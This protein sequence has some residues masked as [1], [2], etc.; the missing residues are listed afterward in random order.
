MNPDAAAAV[1]GGL[2]EVATE[3]QERAAVIDGLLDEAGKSSIAPSDAR[4]GAEL[5]AAVGQDIRMR[6]ELLRTADARAWP[7]AVIETILGAESGAPMCDA[8]RDAGGTALLALKALE[9]LSSG[10]E[11]VAQLTRSFTNSS[12]YV[13]ARA[14]E[15]LLGLGYKNASDFYDERRLP[16]AQRRQMMRAHNRQLGRALRTQGRA[17][18]GAADAVRAN[19]PLTSL[20][21]RFPRASK[22]LKTGGKALGAAGMVVNAVDL[23]GDVNRGDWGGAASNTAAMVGSGLMMSGYGAPVGAVLVAGSLIYEHREEIGKAAEWVGDKVGDVAGD[24]AGS[25]KKAAGKVGDF[26]GL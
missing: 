24:V 5:L 23:V 9:Q 11:S 6:A 8:L 13:A 26:F 10:S 25:A 15:S 12:R 3:L 18:D 17:V 22:V 1:A 16:R 4:A 21:S 2:A 14:K 19:R 7:R 20:G